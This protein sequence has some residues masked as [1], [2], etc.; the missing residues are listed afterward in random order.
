MSASRFIRNMPSTAGNRDYTG[1]GPYYSFVRREIPHQPLWKRNEENKCG[2][3]GECY[4]FR[5][6]CK[7]LNRKCYKCGRYGH[8]ADLCKS[9]NYKPKMMI[10]KVLCACLK[11]Q[12]KKNAFSQTVCLNNDEIKLTTTSVQVNIDPENYDVIQKL[13]M[14]NTALRI[15][16]STQE[17]RISDLESEISGLNKKL[18][19]IPSTTGKTSEQN[20]DKKQDIFSRVIKAAA[21]EQSRI[22]T[23]LCETVLQKLP[24]TL[25]KKQKLFLQK[26]YCEV[27]GSGK[28]HEPDFCN[29]YRLGGR[30]C[31]LCDER[32][33][34]VLCPLISNFL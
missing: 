3:C 8:Y 19:E 11:N 28:Y 2:R 7:A 29:A 6:F 9:K 13:K 32:H 17:K 10:N 34:S 33:F 21:I 16:K 14:E 15:D 31:V 26:F 25:H 30:T 18:N 23:I 1:H 24:Y 4:S 22:S 20:K 12:E 5:H 27:C